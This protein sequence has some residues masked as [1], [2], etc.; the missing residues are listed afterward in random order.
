MVPDR[1]WHNEWMQVGGCV[2]F[3]LVTSCYHPR[4]QGACHATCDPTIGACPG[5]L[6]CMADGLCHGF[7]PPTGK[8]AFVTF[9]TF[10][11]QGAM[12]RSIA[13]ATCI[14]EAGIGSL[15]GIFVAL[16]PTT[17]DAARAHA[18]GN[19]PWLRKDGVSIGTLDAPE[20]PLDVTS[21]G[22]YVDGLV[23]V[24]SGADDPNKTGSI[25]GTCNDWKSSGGGGLVGNTSR[26]K[27]PDFY[28]FGMSDCG[29]PRALRCVEM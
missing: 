24:W 27:L 28:R 14:T 20:A 4:A 17:S 16:W 10:V 26:S 12:G 25:A 23:G 29:Q 9:G 2:L 8:H 15:D 13:D 22:A 3:V 1:S 5:E 6:A 19:G 7:A 21:Q 11:P 18:G